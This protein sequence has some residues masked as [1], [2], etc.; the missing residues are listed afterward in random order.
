MELLKVKEGKY[1]EEHGGASVEFGGRESML[2][3]PQY[4]GKGGAM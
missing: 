1:E 3:F 4:H 2:S